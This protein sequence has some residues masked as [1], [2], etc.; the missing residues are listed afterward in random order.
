MVGVLRWHLPGLG[1]ASALG[2]VDGVA[3]VAEEDR[4]VWYVT[5]ASSGEAL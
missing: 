3:D 4:E 1:Q 2:A 5:G